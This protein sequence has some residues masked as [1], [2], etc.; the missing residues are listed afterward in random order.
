[1]K[2]TL[3]IIIRGVAVVLF[4]MS[5]LSSPAVTYASLS[6]DG[7]V[8]I[9]RAYLRDHAA[10]YSLKPDL[11]DLKLL[12]V[13]AGL[14]ADRVLFQ[15][16]YKEIPVY[17]DYVSV[18]I[19]RK[20]DFPP[21]VTSSYDPYVK[22]SSTTPSIGLDTALSKAEAAIGGAGHIRGNPHTELFVYPR[23]RSGKNAVYTLVWQVTILKDDPPGN[24]DIVVDALSGEIL[25]K[26]DRA[27]R[28]QSSLNQ[29]AVASPSPSVSA[30]QDPVVLVETGTTTRVSVSTDGT[31][32]NDLSD[33]PRISA[34]GRY[35][36]FESW[37]SNLVSGDTNGTDDI[38]VR[39]QQTGQTSRVSIATDGTQ[40]NGG[41]D[42]PTISAD[43][44]YVVFRS[45]ASNLVSGDTNS[46][47][48]IFVRD[49]QTNQTSRVSVATN[50]TQGNDYSDEPAISSDGR[51]V[52]FESWASNLVSGDTNG[53]QDVFIRDR[54]TGQTSRVSVATN[55]TQGNGG[56]Y[57][58]TISADGRYVAFVSSASNLVSGDTNGQQDV[59]IRDQQLGQTSRV[60]VATNGTQGNDGS[61]RTTISADGRYVA[62]A[63][64]ASNLV[65]GDTNG[66][67]DVIVRDRQTGQTSRVSVATDGAQGNDLSDRPSISADGRYVV[68]ESWAS[69][70]VSG[71]TNGQQDVF[72]HD[73]QTGQ[74]SRVSIAT[75]GTQGNGGSYWSTISGDGRY[76]AFASSA[77]NLVSGDT[78]GVYDVFVHDRGIASDLITVKG[79]WVYRDKKGVRQPLP[80]VRVEI[81]DANPSSPGELL[82]TT[83]ASSVGY[84]ETVVVSDEVD[85]PDIY[86]VAYTTDDYSVRVT[87]S[88]SF[89][90]D[91]H[92]SPSED[93]WYNVSGTLDVGEQLWKWYDP[94][95]DAAAYIYDLIADEAWSY[96]MDEADWNNQFNLPVLWSPDSTDGPY[97][98]D[99]S[100][101]IHLHGEQG[102]DPDVTLHEYGHFIM[103]KTYSQYPPTPNCEDHPW[104]APTSLGCAWSEGWADFLQGAIQYDYNYCGTVPS[105]T[106][107]YNMELPEESPYGAEVE[108]A[109]AASLWDI[110]DD[111]ITAESWDSIGLF[112]RPIWNIFYDHDPKDVNEFENRWLNSSN[113]YNAEVQAIFA[114]HGIG[115]NLL[116]N[117]SFEDDANN[118]GK[119]DVWSTS[120]KFTRSTEIPA[121]DGSYVGRF[122]ATDNSGANSTQ[123]VLNL[124]A[125]TTYN[126]SGSVNIPT[127]GDTTFTFKI[128]VIWKNASGSNISTTL[129]KNY[130]A[131]TSGWNQAT[132]AMVAP[133]GTVNAVVKMVASS[134]N[135]SIY[136]DNFFFGGSTGPNTYTLTVNKT[137]TGS[138]TVTSNPAGINCGSDC[139]EAYAPNT[140]VT[141]TATADSGSNFTGWS[142]DCIGNTCTVTMTA[143]TSVTANFDLASTGDLIFANSFEDDDCFTTQWSSCV[144]DGGDLN[145]NGPPLVATGSVSMSVIIDDNHVVYVASDHPIAEPRYRARFYFDPNSISM[146]NGDNHMIF[147]GY[148]GTSTQVVRVLFRRYS[149]NYQ[150]RAAL[151]N[152]GTSW[153]NS[154]WFTIADGPHYLEIDW[155]ASTASGANNGGLTFWIDGVQK[156]NLTGI[157]NDTRKIDQARLGAVNGIDSGTRGTY[158]FDDFVST[159]TTYIGP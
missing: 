71:D 117:P 128:Q 85:G 64:Y 125:G 116:K 83:W 104:A 135:G 109:V 129:V 58:S 137:G 127:Q 21:S 49:R 1:M 93:T 11:S 75:N 119:P 48:D 28:G 17:G 70:L 110:Y 143:D 118:D 159:R 44:R 59:F 146:V 61:Y 30:T 9:A 126:F 57:W 40:G 150:V 120:N 136:V 46:R 7:L 145:F 82:D 20:P 97:Y 96:L 22:V 12:R 29:E 26:F 87:P 33:T 67:L 89:P 147:I 32:G 18:I 50:G 31:Q 77:S 95:P 112:F 91:A 23:D 102:W 142:G 101:V 105:G 52:V 10:E 140:S 154:S 15:Q 34:D 54:Q 124:T 60:S 47:P 69:N 35:V 3:S 107:C 144:D 113:G 80:Y 63:S 53:Q 36:V 38:F 43:G 74:T 45:A 155:K 62:F 13:S 42:R 84:F 134:L 51:Y 122:R 5:L 121:I 132:K 148:S 86:L 92:L 115:I 111:S 98:D 114:H 76:V 65:N 88:L 158:Y 27:I 8:E 131:T 14:E 151:V 2:Q 157:D 55:G 25:G 79:S 41:V 138:G 39:D 141:L 153:T 68:F 73:R 152:D 156:A 24:W 106:K 123:T 94:N 66:Y 99:A 78:N 130:T 6:A 100:E 37:A 16:T 4:F 19:S 139:S 108:G 103:D 72:I 81:W 56:S 90:Y 149:N 133:A